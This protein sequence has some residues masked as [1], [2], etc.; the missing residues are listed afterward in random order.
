MID[1]KRF[2]DGGFYDNLPINLIS[3]RGYKEIVAVELNAI[4]LI[5][6]PKEKSLNI[7]RIVPS[8]DTGS[9]LEF[10]KERSRQNIQMG[11]LDTMH[12]YGVYEGS[13]SI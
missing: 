8:G 6:S 2:L 3:R 7:R 4:G 1:G 9:L 10:D 11:Y 5:Q 13:C 12:S